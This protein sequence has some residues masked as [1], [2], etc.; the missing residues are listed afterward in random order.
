M[1][2]DDID[3]NALNDDELVEQMQDDLYDGLA[4]EIVEGVHILLR[5]AGPP[6]TC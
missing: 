6:T 5:A 2:D 1:A 4:D 3:L